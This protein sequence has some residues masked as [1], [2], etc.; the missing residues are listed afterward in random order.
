MAGRREFERTDYLTAC[1]FGFLAFALAA[2]ASS[3]FARFPDFLHQYVPWAKRIAAADDVSSRFKFV[4]GYPPGYP[5]LLNI[6][7]P[8]Q[9][10]VTA[11]HRIA[12]GAWAG[13]ASASC[14]LA[15][16]LL[17]RGFT[18]VA[19]TLF[20]LNPV[21]LRYASHEWADLPA[22]A[23][24]CA[25]L[26]VLL[27]GGRGVGRGVL[28]G[29]LLAGAVWIRYQ[30][31]IFVGI[32]VVV[33]GH[34]AL[35]RSQADRRAARALLAT[36]AIGLGP[37]L[38]ARWASDGAGVGLGTAIL[39]NLALEKGPAGLGEMILESRGLG[40]AAAVVGWSGVV[41]YYTQR[42]LYL[43]GSLEMIGRPL[44]WLC[45]GGIVLMTAVPAAADVGRP[46]VG[47]LAIKSA[48]FAFHRFD[49]RLMIDTLPIF[50][51][52][53]LF[54]LQ[55]SLD[56]IEPARRTLGRVVVG[57]AVLSSLAGGVKWYLLTE[58]KSTKDE[59][60]HA[61][62]RVLD[63]CGIR[64]AQVGDLSIGLYD[65]RDRS[66]GLFHNV[67]VDVG[68]AKVRNWDQLVELIEGRE[69]HFLVAI[70]SQGLPDLGLF[71]D[72]ARGER[73]TRML[74]AGEGQGRIV[75]FARDPSACSSRD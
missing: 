66:V 37:L 55:T 11:A 15:R 70:P 5:L 53:P 19:G 57:L 6:L 32:A 56:L 69:L 27:G 47:I 13:L 45:W 23:L 10:Y 58:L 29:A 18:L 4:G 50:L 34:R 73:W 75:L 67:L 2:T 74:L 28:V 59:S 12:W 38:L 48:M 62:V 33:Q 3:E 60:H 64:A 1:I 9:D 7:A 36:L 61:L 31:M 21:F 54:L 26:A 30:A 17:G 40:D 35:R 22:A 20:L 63:R 8:D 71:E 39:N 51:I 16:L 52:A 42:L 72:P 65:L 68:R 25:A 41:G 24:A 43:F 44:A 14:L 46:L 49:E